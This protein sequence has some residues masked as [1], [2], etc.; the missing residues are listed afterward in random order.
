MLIVLLLFAI[1]MLATIVSMLELDARDD[2]ARLRTATGVPEP[3]P[4][5]APSASPR[6]I[7]APSGLRL[8]AG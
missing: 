8:A 2:R 3:A 1:A 6:P 5:R 7:P 4:T